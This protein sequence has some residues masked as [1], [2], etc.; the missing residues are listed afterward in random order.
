MNETQV[1]TEEQKKSLCG[2]AW[3]Q[4]DKVANLKTIKQL[5]N[6]ENR[7]KTG[8]KDNVENNEALHIWGVSIRAQEV[9][10]L[11]AKADD[12]PESTWLQ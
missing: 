9:K 4:N 7:E 10:S 5:S 2:H 6:P 12:R 1:S 3:Q 11:V 8:F